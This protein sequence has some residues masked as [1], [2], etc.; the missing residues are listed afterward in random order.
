M[1]TTQRM[2]EYAL[3]QISSK[4]DQQLQSRTL[5]DRPVTEYLTQPLPY[6]EGFKGKHQLLPQKILEGSGLYYFTI[7]TLLK[8]LNAGTTPQT[9]Q[10]RQTYSGEIHVLPTYFQSCPI[11]SKSV[12]SG[13]YF[14]IMNS[15]GSCF[16]ALTACAKEEVSMTLA[17]TPGTHEAK[18]QLT[19]PKNI[20][21]ETRRAVLIRHAALPTG[22]AGNPPRPP[23][24]AMRT[25]TSVL[26]DRN[27]AIFNLKQNTTAYQPRIEPRGIL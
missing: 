5:P 12:T 27:A 13:P 24:P 7:L 16:S 2:H 10:E 23:R 20:T 19:L 6:L 17:R 9:P 11:R 14:I 18:T 21:C 25:S 22:R 15:I 3:E 8:T 26:V 1:P 4:E